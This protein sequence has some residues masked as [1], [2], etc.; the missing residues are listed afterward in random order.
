MAIADWFISKNDPGVA[1]ALEIGA[2]I[3]GT[4]S[5][6][7][8]DAGSPA[9][10]N[11]SHVRLMA[12]PPSSQF[13]KG[14][15][16]TLMQ[17][18][19]FTDAASSVSFFGCIGM[20]SQADVW[21]AGGQGYFAGR[22]GGASPSWWIA[23]VDNGITMASDFTMLA[24]GDTTNLPSVGTVV[25]IEFEWIYDPLEFNGVRL[26][27]RVGTLTDFSDLAD[28][29]T[30]IDSSPTALNST[31]G[32]GLFMSDV[33]TALGPDVEVLFD[34]TTNFELVPV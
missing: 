19:D 15:V 32:E 9:I 31:I 30:V 2:P 14:K 12:G 17:P 34:K 25:P 21:A 26:I 8:A 18:L 22:W 1:T 6:R 33:R 29:Y 24:S 16:R 11:N 10:V 28:I 4:G 7:M 27:F 20:M 23:R 5:L 13:L 3:D